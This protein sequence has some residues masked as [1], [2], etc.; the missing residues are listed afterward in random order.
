MKNNDLL[1]SDTFRAVM[2]VAKELKSNE[3]LMESSKTKVEKTISLIE[4]LLDKTDDPDQ[5]WV[6]SYFAIVYSSTVY[7]LRPDELGKKQDR[8]YRFLSKLNLSLSEKKRI[9]DE[10][11]KMASDVYGSNSEKTLSIT[12]HARDVLFSSFHVMRRL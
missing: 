4:D 7:W 8:A 3:K 1:A 6:E 5:T 11:R 9:L 12:F 10:I 2:S